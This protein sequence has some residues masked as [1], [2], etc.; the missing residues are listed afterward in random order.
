MR[1]QAENR[2]IQEANRLKSEFLANMS[3]ELRTPLNAVIGF[4]E[5]LRGNVALPEA[6]RNEYLNHI[7]ASGRHLLRLI[8][9]VL[10]L[11]K[12]ESGKFDSRARAAAVGAR[13]CKK[14]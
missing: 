1:L 8:N 10:D 9:D 5:I 4:A 14:W 12:V 6:K 7:A 3:H 11:S 13:W 2:Q